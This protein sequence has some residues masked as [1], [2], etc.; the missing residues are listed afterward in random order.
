[1][2]IHT[3]TVSLRICVCESLLGAFRVFL[4]TP[5]T[6]F[7]LSVRPSVCIYVLPLENLSVFHHVSSQ[8]YSMDQCDV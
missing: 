7:M 3:W 4:K 6:L 2:I 8:L 5:I 1:M